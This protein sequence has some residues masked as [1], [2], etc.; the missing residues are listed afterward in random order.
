LAEA[1][2][3]TISTISQRLRVLRNENIVQRRRRGKQIISCSPTNTLW[4]WCS[5]PLA[6]AGEVPASASQ[7]HVGSTCR[8]S[9][10]G[11]LLY[12]ARAVKRRL[13]GRFF[14]FLST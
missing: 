4:I 13:T 6:H 14:E 7:A 5:T 1:E 11:F 12:F 10:A 8:S 2:G 3:E 9:P